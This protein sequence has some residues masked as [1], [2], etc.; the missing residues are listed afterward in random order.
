M[1]KIGI[2]FAMKEELENE[3]TAIEDSIK[4]EMTAQNV[5]E[6]NKNNI[7]LF[8]A[9]YNINSALKYPYYSSIHFIDLSTALF[10]P[11]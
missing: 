8:N 5:N 2:I 3:I 6:L 10:H 11:L 7:T 1:K 4:A 9:L